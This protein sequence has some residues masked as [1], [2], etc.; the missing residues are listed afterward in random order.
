MA[1]IPGYSEDSS[2]EEWEKATP[3][4]PPKK[5]NPWLDVIDE[6][7]AGQIRRIPVADMN[8]LKGLR[9]G[10]ARLA[11]SRQMKLEFRILD[12]NLMVRRS[13]RE[14]QAP[15]PKPPSERKPGRPRKQPTEE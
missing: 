15:E 6:V 9:I 4:Q 10:L 5:Q 7:E 12:G 1:N 2:E 13:G 8:K 11:A 3:P 14:Y